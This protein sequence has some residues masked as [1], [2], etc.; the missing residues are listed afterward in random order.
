MASEQGQE[1]AERPKEG[2]L[3][4]QMIERQQREGSN[5]GGYA[6]EL[7]RSLP[8]EEQKDKERGERGET[9]PPFDSLMAGAQSYQ[10]LLAEASQRGMPECER[11][12]SLER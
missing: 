6:R 4:Q 8:E 7:L 5:R 3:W 12:N 2:E 1:Y 10:D 9:S 11:D